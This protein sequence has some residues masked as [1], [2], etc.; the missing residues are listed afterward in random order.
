MTEDDESGPFGIRILFLVLFWAI[1]WG[2]YVGNTYLSWGVLSEFLPGLLKPVYRNILIIAYYC[3]VA[4]NYYRL[5][6]E[7]LVFGPKLTAF[8]WVLASLTTDFLFWQ[9]IFQASSEE[10]LKLYVTINGVFYLF[11]IIGLFLAPILMFRIRI[12]I[13]KIIITQ[14][15]GRSRD[16]Q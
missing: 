11:G 9:K 1:C 16:F 12:E 14:E 2:G 5:V 6:P 15:T 13:E 7:E 8:F 10:M 4:Y 3:I